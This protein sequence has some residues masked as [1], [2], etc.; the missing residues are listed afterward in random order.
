V[1]DDAQ[2]SRRI[3]QRALCGSKVNRT[4]RPLRRLRENYGFL[5][6]S[7]RAAWTLAIR[8]T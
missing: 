6:I 8:W 5:Y 1:I 4:A 7:E 2:T 3:Y